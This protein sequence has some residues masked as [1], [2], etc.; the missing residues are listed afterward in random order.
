MLNTVMQHEMKQ[1]ISMNPNNTREKPNTV[2]IY[3]ATMGGV[4]EVDKRIK[5]YQS[6]RKAP[7]WYK[8]IYF[9]AMDLAVY[10]CFILYRYQTRKKTTYLKFL[11]QLIEEIFSTHQLSRKRTGRPLSNPIVKSARLEGMHFPGKNYKIK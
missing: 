1:K 5:P 3:N 9:H 6:R 4:N 8:I 11:L 2:L 7:K 10:N